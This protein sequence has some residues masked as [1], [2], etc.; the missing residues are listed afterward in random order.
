MADTEGPLKTLRAFKRVTLK[1]GGQQMVDID[2]P[3]DRFECWDRK[4]NTMRVV[5]G[6]YEL[7]VGT[8]SADSDL[9]KV[10]V[11]VK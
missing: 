7:M 4:T 9:Q 10:V 2:L 1:A 5:P 3:R 11:T 8:S 6:K